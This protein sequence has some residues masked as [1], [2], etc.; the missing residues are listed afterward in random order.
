M[1]AAGAIIGGY[2]GPILARKVGARVV[3]GFVT[4]VGFAIGIYFLVR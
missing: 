3:R 2:S 4:F 1:L